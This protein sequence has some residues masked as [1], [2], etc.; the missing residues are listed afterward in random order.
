MFSFS[1]HLPSSTL[2]RPDFVRDTFPVDTNARAYVGLVPDLMPY[3][4]MDE[5]WA[6]STQ[7]VYQFFRRPMGNHQ[8]GFVSPHLPGVEGLR[9]K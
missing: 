8:I 2:E 6:T 7:I 5:F 1:Q 9:A 3:Q 4:R